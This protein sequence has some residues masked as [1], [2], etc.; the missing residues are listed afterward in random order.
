[1]KEIQDFTHCQV[2][3][4]YQKLPSEFLLALVS[5]IALSLIVLGPR[6]KEPPLQGFVLGTHDPDVRRTMILRRRVR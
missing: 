3:L 2:Y 5:I 4:T 1:M 6:I